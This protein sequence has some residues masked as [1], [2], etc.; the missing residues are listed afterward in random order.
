MQTVALFFQYAAICCSSIVVA[1]RVKEP[2]SS[3]LRR[4]IA[5]CRTLISTVLRYLSVAYIKVEKKRSD[6]YI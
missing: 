2:L 6:I 1:S 3:G 4:T 5:G